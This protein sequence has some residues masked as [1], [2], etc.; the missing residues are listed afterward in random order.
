MKRN[1]QPTDCNVRPNEA[2]GT[3]VEYSEADPGN[4]TSI[5]GDT[6]LL[7][8]LRIPGYRIDRELGRGGMGVV[9]LAEQVALQRL[10]ALKV[11]LHSGLASP[12][13]VARFHLEA[14]ALGRLRHPNVVQV[15]A[16]GT[17]DG[18]AYMAMEY[19]PR[20][21]LLHRLREGPPLSPRDIAQLLERVARGLEYAHR[22]GVLHRDL[23]PANLL[24]DADD[25][26]KIADFG[27]ARLDANDSGLTSTGHV[28]GTPHYL[29]P[30]QLGGDPTKVGPASDVYA[31]GVILFECLTGHVPFDVAVPGLLFQTILYHDPPR[32]RA[33]APD[34]PRDLEV[35]CLKCLEKAPGRRYTSAEALADDLRRFLDGRPIHARPIGTGER[36]WKWLRR[37]PLL[38]GSGVLLLVAL[39]LLGGVVLERWQLRTARLRELEATLAQV[40]ELRRR[41]EFAAALVAAECAERE[42]GTDAE[43]ALSG[44]IDRTLRET[45][46]LALRESIELGLASAAPGAFAPTARKYHAEVTQALRD[47]GIDADG[48]PDQAKAAMDASPLRQDIIDMLHVRAITL[49]RLVEG[50]R[51]ELQ[52]LDLF[53]PDPWRYEFRQTLSQP[54]DLAASLRLIDNPAIAQQPATYGVLLA[55]T[56]MSDKTSPTQIACRDLVRRLAIRFPQEPAIHVSL[57][58]S[59]MT[60]SQSDHDL[61]E[62]A[63]CFRSVLAL[64]PRSAV[65]ANNLGAVLARLGREEEAVEC[66]R[67]ALRHHPTDVSSRSNFGSAIY[68]RGLAHF[69]GGRWSLA[70][71]DFAAAMAT[72]TNPTRR[73]APY[74]HLARYRQGETS[75][76][77]EA[78]AATVALTDPGWKWREPRDFVDA[79]R[80][81]ALAFGEPIGSESHLARCLDLLRS[82]RAAGY[83]R[84]FDLVDDP[85]FMPVRCR[86]E[87]HALLWE[88]AADSEP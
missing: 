65:A 33:L 55:R 31:L 19:L 10:V 50:K 82:A 30:E 48:E 37:R 52:R 41:G 39:I 69:Y 54:I 88:W 16:F 25:S 5:D 23:K 80:V 28:M 56:L 53:D 11:L 59:L 86:N 45:R 8:R 44:R 60:K 62:A 13:Q 35:I 76:L 78:L 17:C 2:S 72:N 66:F 84:A 58:Y 83:R 46:F 68:R 38:A 51:R 6:K 75:A 63:G 27:L 29:A 1:R 21:S 43:P 18:H 32:P 15:Y 3:Q 47:L 42:I 22:Q 87:F 49:N 12:R 36:V 57:G 71:D 9:Y 4:A 81:F 64:Q 24:L 70:Q 85:I 73:A 20:A 34:V 67:L 61:L 79:A 7:P 74:F 26:P 40:D 14:E 77:D